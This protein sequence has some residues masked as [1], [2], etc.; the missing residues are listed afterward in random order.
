LKLLKENGKTDD[1][2]VAINNDIN[3]PA[4]I[5]TPYNEENAQATA[6]FA[7]LNSELIENVALTLNG[8]SVWHEDGHI[9]FEDNRM[10]VADN[11]NDALSPLA[12]G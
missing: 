2:L 5:N 1:G 7:T 11:I 6:F 12:Q 4:N 3:Q 8:P 9:L 10:Y